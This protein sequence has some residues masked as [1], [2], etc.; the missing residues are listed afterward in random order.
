MLFILLWKETHRCLAHS[1]GEVAP[2]LGVELKEGVDEVGNL[3]FLAPYPPYELLI[4]S[5]TIPIKP[6]DEIINI[7]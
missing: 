4:F 7:V 1:L 6:S 5:I 3:W 2:D